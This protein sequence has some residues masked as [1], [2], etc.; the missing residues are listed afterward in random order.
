MLSITQTK[1][2]VPSGRSVR[3]ESALLREA[4]TASLDSTENTLISVVGHPDPSTEGKRL[5]SK[6]RSLASKMGHGMSVGFNAEKGAVI[7]K[8]TTEVRGKADS[9]PADTAQTEPAIIVAQAAPV[10]PPPRKRA[11]TRKG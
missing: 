5:A 6:L 7:F 10:S 8:A 2:P 9:V 3:D 4:I 11:Q 1:D